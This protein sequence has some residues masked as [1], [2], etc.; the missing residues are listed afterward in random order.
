MEE[1]DAYW[2]KLLYDVCEGKSSEMLALKKF[3]IIEF[4]DY[5]TNKTKDG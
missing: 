2:N 1:L 3:D 5:M 4:F